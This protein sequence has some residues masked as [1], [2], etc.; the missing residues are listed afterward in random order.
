MLDGLPQQ[1]IHNDANELNVLVGP[2][3][4]VSGL[5]DFGDTVWSARVCGLAVAAAYAMQG[6]NDPLREVLPLVR[7]YHAV[8]PLRA[9]ELAVLFALMRAAARGLGVH[10]G[11]AVRQRSRQRVPACQPGRDRAAARAAGGSRTPSS[12]TSASATPADTRRTRA[13]GRCGTG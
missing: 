8:T 9:D 5:I 10:G 1:V 6:L 7:G 13:R 4:A 12:R 2:D 3:G 11:V